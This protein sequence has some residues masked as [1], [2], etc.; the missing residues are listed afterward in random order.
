[1]KSFIDKTSG[2]CQGVH[3]QAT[4]VRK[5]IEGCSETGSLR[6]AILNNIKTE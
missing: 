2:Q 5:Q 4:G 6:S 1:M 3:R